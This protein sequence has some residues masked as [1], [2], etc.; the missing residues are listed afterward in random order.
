MGKRTLAEGGRVDAPHQHAEL[1]SQYELDPMLSFRGPVQA[2]CGTIS[3]NMR[4]KVTEIRMAAHDGTSLSRKIGSDLRRHCISHD[5]RTPHQYYT[6]AQPP[7][8]SDQHKR[9]GRS[10]LTI[11]IT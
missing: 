8:P 7:S 4:I 6:I 11:R 2:A 10:E 5:E 1:I 3:P 9:H